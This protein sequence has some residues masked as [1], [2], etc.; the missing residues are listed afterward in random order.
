MG[1]TYDSDLPTAKDKV[2]FMVGDVERG[3]QLIEDGEIN[4]ALASTGNNLHKA[5]AVCCRAMSARLR[6]E[7]TLNPAAGSLSLD[8]QV[9]ADGFLELAEKFER[10]ALLS[11]GAG[12][13]AGGISKAGK[14]SVEQ[15]RDRVLPAFT[16]NRHHPSQPGSERLSQT[17][18]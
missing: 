10:E 9:Q 4:F 15:D 13:F 3:D 16:A 17:D 6:R 18:D 5:A 7:L 11:G 12:I 14:R 2:R 1:W 8:S